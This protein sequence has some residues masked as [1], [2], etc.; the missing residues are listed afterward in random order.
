MSQAPVNI[1]K[2]PTLRPAE[3][4]YRLRREGIGYIEQMG[5][6]Q[7]TDY[8]LHDPGITLLEALAFAITDLA[9]R[10]GWSIED[11]LAPAPGETA[12]HQGFHTARH[13]LTINPWTPDDFRR[14]LI[15]RDRV[16]NAWVFCK[17]C[18]CDLHY[19]AWCDVDNQLQLSFNK[20]DAA[21]LSTQK[22]EPPGLYEALLEL[23]SDPDLGDLNDRKIE[24]T[25][26]AYDSDHQP[27]PRLA[28][29]CVSPRRLARPARRAVRQRLH[30]GEGRADRATGRSAVGG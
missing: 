7:W 19:F 1:P 16:R 25:L 20:T 17:K 12:P 23:E 10:T 9:Y 6:R 22:V 8:N 30:D 26:F 24:Q 18:A 5:S 3:D 11:L 13:I 15:D 28:S 2:Q 4:F 21:G 27:H 14:L 29:A